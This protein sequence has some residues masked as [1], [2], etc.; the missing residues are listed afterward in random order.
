MLIFDVEHILVHIFTNM[1]FL[2]LCSVYLTYKIIYSVIHCNGENQNKDQIY[3]IM[4]V[5]SW[6]SI[7]H[8][9]C[10][11]ATIFKSDGSHEWKIITES[12]HE[13]QKNGIH[14]DSC[15]VFFSYMPFYVLVKHT[16]PLNQSLVVHFAIFCKDS[17]FWL[18][19]VMS[20]CDVRWTQGTGIVTSSSSIVLACVNKCK[21]DIH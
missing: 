9:W 8:E 5:L 21:D 13:W 17:L 15:T 3:W 14:D 10:H 19:I 2:I 12:C 20:I 11:S 7:F 6:I 1:N 18:V 4:Y 16:T